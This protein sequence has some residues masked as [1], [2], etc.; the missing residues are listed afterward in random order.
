MSI[1]VEKSRFAALKI[2]DDDEIVPIKQNGKSN[3]QQQQQQQQKQKQQ[4]L[5][6]KGQT[7][8]EIVQ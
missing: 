6:K 8:N 5:Q 7:K 3:K 1:V 2:E 4:Q